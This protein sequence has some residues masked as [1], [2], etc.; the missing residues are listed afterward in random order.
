MLT[1][2]AKAGKPD[3]QDLKGLEVKRLAATFTSNR[4]AAVIFY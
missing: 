2:A 1:S 4:L 3:I